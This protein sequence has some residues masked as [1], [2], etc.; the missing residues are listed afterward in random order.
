MTHLLDRHNRQQ[1][2]CKLNRW[3]VTALTIN[4]DLANCPNCVPVPPMPGRPPRPRS[5]PVCRES[6]THSE[7]RAHISG[8]GADRKI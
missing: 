7:I 3:Q 8:C 2:V 4:P 5:C 1:T 6:F